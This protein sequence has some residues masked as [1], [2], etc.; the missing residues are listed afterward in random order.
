M[1]HP[2]FAQIMMHKDKLSE[3]LGQ[4]FEEAGVINAAVSVVSLS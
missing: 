3:R 4:S 2:S 1:W